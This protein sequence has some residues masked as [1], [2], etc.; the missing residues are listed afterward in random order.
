M[1]VA[2]RCSLDYSGLEQLV[3]VR[4]N[5]SLGYVEGLSEYLPLGP[6]WH[7]PFVFIYVWMHH[8]SGI[9]VKPAGL[10]EFREARLLQIRW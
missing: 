5:K 3:L 8:S 7:F 9:P 4:A 10:H 6:T 1:A 2:K